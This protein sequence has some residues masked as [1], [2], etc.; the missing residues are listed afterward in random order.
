MSVLIFDYGFPL[1]K[2]LL[3]SLLTLRFDDLE[4][5]A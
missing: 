3:N 2:S 5:I 1:G 4:V